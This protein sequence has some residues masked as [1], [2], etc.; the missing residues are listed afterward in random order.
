MEPEASRW[1]FDALYAGQWRNMV[2]LAVLLID[3]RGSAGLWHRTGRQ[4]G[5]PARSS[6]PGRPARQAASSSIDVRSGLGRGSVEVVG[7]VALQ[8]LSTFVV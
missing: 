6:M 4:V 3:D 8:R 7:V 1:D 5:S 2:R